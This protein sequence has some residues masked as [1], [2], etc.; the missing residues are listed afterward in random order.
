MCHNAAWAR[1]FCIYLEAPEWGFLLI[2]SSL[3]TVALSRHLRASWERSRKLWS[4]TGSKQETQSVPR[5][6]GLLTVDPEGFA[7]GL[8]PSTVWDQ[9]SRVEGTHRESNSSW[10]VT[11]PCFRVPVSGS[12]KQTAF[13]SLRLLTVSSIVPRIKG[14][15]P[16]PKCQSLQE[17][18]PAPPPQP[19]CFFLIPACWA[20][21]TLV[22]TR[23]SWRASCSTDGWV[24]VSADLESGLGFWISSKSLGEADVDNEGR[25][26]ETRCFR[27]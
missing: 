14:I 12:F 10:S 19:A 25:H 3:S 26:C 7:P 20:P 1:R 4:V 22:C 15:N 23:L 8:V 16:P 5:P 9:S 24:S 27:F 21:Q 6:P 17:A 11:I 18:F 13:F 2:L